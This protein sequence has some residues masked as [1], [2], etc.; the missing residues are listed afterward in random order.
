MINNQ[1]AQVHMR[2]PNLPLHMVKLSMVHRQHA[3]KHNI[4]VHFDSKVSLDHSVDDQEEVR[5]ELGLVVKGDLGGRK[6]SSNWQYMASMH[7]HPK[8]S[9]TCLG[10]VLQVNAWFL[11]DM[12]W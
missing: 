7:S 6:G 8:D 2:N 4:N 12:V 11:S 9:A 10:G 3:S 1:T 5:G